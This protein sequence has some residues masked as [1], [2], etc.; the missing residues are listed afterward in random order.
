[1]YTWVFLR[2]GTYILGN[3]KVQG[4]TTDQELLGF[5]GIVIVFCISLWAIFPGTEPL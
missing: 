4:R 2:K 1:M 5:A 3:M